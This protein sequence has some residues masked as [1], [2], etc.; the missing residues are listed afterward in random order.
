MLN[1]IETCCTVFFERNI[2]QIKIEIIELCF[3]RLDEITTRVC[4]LLV[5]CNFAGGHFARF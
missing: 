3:L 4:G 5:I 1:F 2:K